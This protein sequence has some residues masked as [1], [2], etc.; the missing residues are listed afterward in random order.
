VQHLERPPVTV[1]AGD[2]AWGR[3]ARSR[4][5]GLA[6][7]PAV[8]AVPQPREP[9]RGP[10]PPGASAAPRRAPVPRREQPGRLPGWVLAVLGAVV[11]AGVVSGLRSPGP[12][13][14]PDVEASVRVA[15]EVHVSRSGEVV[16]PVRVVNTGSELVVRESRVWAAP[17]TQEPVVS[18][19]SRLA[20]DAERG[21]VAV[22][23]PDCRYLRP[24]FDVGFSATLAL[25]VELAT[26]ERR[27]VIG[28]LGRAPLV[29]ARVA[30]LCARP[31]PA[32]SAPAG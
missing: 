8:P 29:A 12:R 30:G 7:A 10:P 31:E 15:G 4:S 19:A 18:G 16:V 21:M 26:G 25:Q 17:V 1:T 3:A 24:G 11:V 28:D 9:H 27:Q 2:D 6:G 32:G 22:L 23:R 5:G 13:L 14:P 20:A